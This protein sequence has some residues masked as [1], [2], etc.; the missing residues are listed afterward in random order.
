[1]WFLGLQN[2]L[3]NL[4][5]QAES[6]QTSYNSSQQELEE[7]RASALEACQEVEEGDVQAGSSMASRLRALGRHV[8]Q[9]L[10]R[11][12]H[13]GVQK[14]LGVVVSHYQVNLEAVSTGYVVPVGVDDEVA[15]DRADALVAPAAD[16]LAE[17]FTD[18]PFPDAP[19]AG[20]PQA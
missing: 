10:R 2:T 19:P 9:R 16:I 13:L 7:L 12:L 6:L 5:T 8:T 18:F 15:M 14:A 20:G 1:L 4:T 3:G 11:A 17:D